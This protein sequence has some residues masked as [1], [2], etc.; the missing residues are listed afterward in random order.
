MLVM[1]RL[2]RLRR[3]R[4]RRILNLASS[5]VRFY[6]I[7]A[8]CLLNIVLGALAYKLASGK[9]WSSAAFT[10]YSVLL[11][12]PGADVLSEERAVGLFVLDVIFLVGLVFFAVLLGMVAEEV[13]N[14]VRRRA[15]PGRHADP[16][17]EVP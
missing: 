14:Q 12:V 5:R 4:W 11:D 15:P 7:V 10:V 8:V 16:Q 3:W 6:T 17:S 13:A 9:R 2:T 1:S